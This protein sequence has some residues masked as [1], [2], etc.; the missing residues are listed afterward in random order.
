MDSGFAA[1]QELGPET[2]DLKFNLTFLSP[3]PPG[4]RVPY[5]IARMFYSPLALQNFHAQAAFACVGRS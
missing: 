2:I 5:P 4:P 1:L 3:P